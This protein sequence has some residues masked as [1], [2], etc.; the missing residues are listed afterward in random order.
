M[1]CGLRRA[2][3][4][5]VAAAPGKL[6]GI[7]IFLRHDLE[8]IESVGDRALPLA[9]RNVFIRKWQ[10][11]VFLNGKIVEQVIALED[12]SDIAFGQ[13][14][15][16]FAFHE[17]GGLL[18]EPVFAGPLVVEKRQHVQRGGLSRS[19][20]SHHG[21]KFALPNVEIDP[22]QYPNISSAGLV[23]AFDIFSRIISLLNSACLTHSAEPP[24][25]L[26]WLHG[27]RE[28]STPALRTQAAPL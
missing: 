12:H 10:I 27:V 13:L 5:Q 24:W 3:S 20:G 17:V 26:R 15:P 16:L 1:G 6:V 14:A 18:A 22:A 4:L 19:G 7:E 2:R 25:D 21:D 9:S 8:A 11:N 28:G 23:V